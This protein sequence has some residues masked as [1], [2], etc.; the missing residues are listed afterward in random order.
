MITQ[1]QPDYLSPSDDI[2]FLASTLTPQ[3]TF[4]HTNT[5]NALCHHCQ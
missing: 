5:R 3:V 1:D 2:H 4:G